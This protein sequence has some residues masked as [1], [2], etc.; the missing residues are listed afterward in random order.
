M[1]G[2]ED[3]DDDG[4]SNPGLMMFPSTRGAAA[5]AKPPRPAPPRPPRSP[6]SST[7]SSRSASP[8][9]TSTRGGGGGGGEGGGG[10]SPIELVAAEVPP[11][12]PPVV[13]DD[14]TPSS[15]E[16]SRAIAASAAAA[17]AAGG[18]PLAAREGADRRRRGGG[19]GGGGGET[20]AASAAAAAANASAS[21]RIRRLGRVAW[22]RVG[23]AVGRG[24]RA[25]RDAQGADREL[26]RAARAIRGESEVRTSRAMKRKASVFFSA[27]NAASFLVHHLSEFMNRCI[28][29]TM[30]NTFST[31]PASISSP[32][33]SLRSE[34]RHDD[35]VELVPREPLVRLLHELKPPRSGLV[36]EVQPPLPGEP[37]ENRPVAPRQRL[38]RVHDRHP[39]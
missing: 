15:P 11:R 30:P 13:H 7:R 1:F 35:V 8:T 12:A 14:A 2:G 31:A 39:S 20:A 34:L 5:G 19:D 38:Q 24:R 16:R 26:T 6:G 28:D 33:S 4:W 32:S 27:L 29:A 18:E 9:S 21:E 17:A 22:R 37:L 3:A 25:R 36:L 10:L 23:G